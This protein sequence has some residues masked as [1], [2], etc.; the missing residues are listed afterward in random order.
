MLH[1]QRRTG[2]EST[3]DRH[4]TRSSIGQAP[5]TEIRSG[6]LILSAADLDEAVNDALNDASLQASFEDL[7]PLRARVTADMTKRAAE[8]R[9]DFE[10]VAAARLSYERSRNRVAFKKRATTILCGIPA[11]WLVLLAAIDIYALYHAKTGNVIIWDPGPFMQSL[12][13]P[14]D[15]EAVTA[16]QSFA[17][18][19]LLLVILFGIWLFLHR[20]FD[21]DLAAERDD[22]WRHELAFRGA[23]TRKVR[24][25]ALT[26]AN[27]EFA[28]GGEQ[29]E[30]G[31]VVLTT[32]RAP[33]LIELEH[34]KG[35]ISSRTHR[36]IQE[37]IREHGSTAIGIAGPRGVGKSTIM[38]SLEG[39]PDHLAV[40]IP[41]PVY[42]S[43]DDFVRRLRL[44]VAR[45]IEI[46]QPGPPR[47]QGSW[48]TLGLIAVL[49]A[50]GSAAT[51]L[52]TLSVVTPTIWSH[53]PGHQ[54]ASGWRL[55]L[56]TV[57]VT[58]AVAVIVLLWMR[59]R[60]KSSA[61]RKEPTTTA[62][63]GT[64]ELRSLE[65]HTSIQ[66]SRRW[67]L[68][69]GKASYESSEGETLEERELSQ[70]ESVSAFRDFIR[71]YTKLSDL[72]VIVTIDELDKIGD[73]AKAVELINGVKD[74]FHID[75]THF[76]VSVSEEALAGFALRGIEVRDVFDSA[77]DIV[78]DVRPLTVD[79][80]LQLLEGRVLAFPKAIG[81]LCHSV[82]GGLPRDLIRC[83]RFC[84]T[85]RKECGEPVSLADLTSAL[86]RS[87]LSSALDAALRVGLDDS[88]VIEILTLRERIA[89][90]AALTNEVISDLLT[91]NGDGG[92]SALSVFAA[93]L[94]TI[95]EYFS[96]PL[97]RGEWEQLIDAGDRAAR[98][99]ATA[100]ATVK[101]TIPLSAAAAAV[102]LDSARRASGLAPISKTRTVTLPTK[103]SPSRSEP[104]K[105]RPAKI[106][107][108]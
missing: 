65:W 90:G 49:C 82:S 102:S 43:A 56:L 44:D 106:R 85:Y 94:E 6:E 64:R 8:L 103:A 19:V 69:F 24:T 1:L 39:M 52:L 13:Q 107:A 33:Q 62:E 12:A 4:A 91:P 22:E 81:L 23:L 47:R 41:I 51:L 21:R 48:L 57:S 104:A 60:A 83:A 61:S 16:S 67:L 66:T 15:S 101:Q 92:A 20:R 98:T 72:P 2:G 93:F 58:T 99:C 95:C 46:S 37:L 10:P 88:D 25:L 74:L 86:A 5:W 77:F 84:I 78:L 36:D 14:G 75:G 7:E 89:G 70:A 71:R 53:V 100:F 59:D 34:T 35:T 80:S 27:T 108:G 38:H 96:R 30:N 31:A 54:H 29:A 97:D 40:Y 55:A 18:S 76:V 9:P 26:L 68:P 3:R 11:F 73:P 63:L 32:V 42:Y 105:E 87:E 50:I 45:V 79:E 17:G 28:R